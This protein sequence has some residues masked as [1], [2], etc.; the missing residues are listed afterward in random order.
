MGA[1]E[2]AA[3]TIA[4]SNGVT[5]LHAP[6]SSSAYVLTIVHA[7]LPNGGTGPFQL[8]AT[9]NP[10]IPVGPPQVEVQSF[11]TSTDEEASTSL[12]IAL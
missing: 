10:P 2:G 11:D 1:G 4:G 12:F 5:V 9:V 6:P 7:F 3:M 8:S